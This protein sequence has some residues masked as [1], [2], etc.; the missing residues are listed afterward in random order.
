MVDAVEEPQVTISHPD[1]PRRA[2]FQGPLKDAKEYIEKHFP[3][4]SHD[5]NGGLIMSAQ[6]NHPDGGV[7]TYHDGEWTEPVSETH[8]P[9]EPAEPE[10]ATPD[11]PAFTL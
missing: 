1:T 11:A 3:R 8:E 2:I 7:S 5:G 9:A 10:P 4:H 6:I